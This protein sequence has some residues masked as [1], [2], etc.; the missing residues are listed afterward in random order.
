MKLEI[1][2]HKEYVE[3]LG[4][5]KEKIRRSQLKAAVR[6]NTEFFNLY[7]DLGRMIVEKQNSSKWGDG[8]IKQL[9]ND[10]QAEFTGVQ[11]FSLSNLKYV[12][13]WYLFYNQQDT[14]SQQLVGQ[15]HSEKSQ[16]A[17]GQ[18]IPE[19]LAYVP[20]GHH[21]HT[22]TKVK[23]AMNY[24]ASCLQLNKSRSN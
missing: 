1:A 4:E 3:C 17:V 23:P 12:R 10:L 19:Q 14:M 16:Q 9:S 22:I 11:G 24:S 18:L 6:L 7:W 13:K 8:L 15:L 20:W 21:M 2:S 5:I